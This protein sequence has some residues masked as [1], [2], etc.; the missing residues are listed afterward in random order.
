MRRTCLSIGVSRAEGLAPL[1]AAATAA[2][3][4]GRWAE[5]SGFAAKEDI[6]VLTDRTD[7][8]TVERIAEAL[9]DLLPIGVETNTL[10]LHFAGHG[11]REDN[12]RTLWLP[13]NWRSELRA[14][15]VERLKNRLSD[16][17]IANRPTACLGPAPA[18]ACDPSSTGSTPSTTSKRPL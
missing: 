17:G 4:V 15:A 11:L 9:G 6:R 1:R 14:I 7:P 10:L 13:T 3:E 12:T 5:L 16:Y 18:L 2:E 8:V